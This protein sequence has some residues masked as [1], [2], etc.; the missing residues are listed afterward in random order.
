[1]WSSLRFAPIIV[2][3]I[4]INKFVVHWLYMSQSLV[5]LRLSESVFK[6]LLTVECFLCGIFKIKGNMIE[7]ETKRFITGEK[8]GKSLSKIHQGLQHAHY[9]YQALQNSN[10]L[11][12]IS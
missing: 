7:N 6:H 5:S 1:M 4:I 11:L 10:K 9:D 12:L 2:F 8:R 3:M